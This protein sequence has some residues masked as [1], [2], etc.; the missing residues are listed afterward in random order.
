MSENEKIREKGSHPR[1]DLNCNACGGLGWVLEPG[2]PNDPNRVY[3]ACDCTKRKAGDAIL[4]GIV[5]GL[6]V[7]SLMLYINT[8]DEAQRRANLS[9]REVNQ[10]DIIR[11]EPG[12]SALTVFGPAVV[13]AGVGWALTELTDDGKS[14]SSRDNDVRVQTYYGNVNV[15]LA[16]DSDTDTTTRTDTRTDTWRVE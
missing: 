9:G 6:C 11:E 13:G 14:S 16:G 1:S 5:L 10:A 3:I 2:E 7:G 15:T 4:L 12:K 8:G